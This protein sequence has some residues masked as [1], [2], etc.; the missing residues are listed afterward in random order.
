MSIKRTFFS[1]I[2]F[3][4][5][6]T[7]SGCSTMKYEPVPL[8]KY[9]DLQKF[10]GAW[11]VI[12]HIPSFPERNAFNAIERYE[13]NDNGTI[14]ATFT[15][16]DGSFEGK[17]KTLTPTG[18]IVDEKSNAVWGMQFI[19]PIKADYRIAY[20]DKEY[21][22]TVIAREKRDYVWVMARK[23]AVSPEEYSKLIDFVESLGYEKSL[24]RKVPQETN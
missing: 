24:I 5:L 21:T 13:L 4:I 14:A 8:V 3:I 9:V 7:I 11:Y 6:F 20:L 1:I 19:W 18:F 10:M 12:A 2:S 15:F 17:F 22:Q 23:P 16:N